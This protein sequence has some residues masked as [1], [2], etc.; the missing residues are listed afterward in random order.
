M[1]D[2]GTATS[3]TLQVVLKA[4]DQFTPVIQ[5][6]RAELARFKTSAQQVVAAA[7]RP[8]TQATQ[9]ATQ[10]TREY[11]QVLYVVDRYG[12]VTAKTLEGEV[13]PALDKVKDKTKDATDAAK[14]H[15]QQIS[16]LQRFYMMFKNILISMFIYFALRPLLFGMQQLITNYAEQE[17][18]LFR[19]SAVLKSTGFAARATATE[20]VDLAE[21]LQRQ[22]IYSDEAIERVEAI[23]LTFTKLKAPVLK[24]AV[25]AVLDMSAVLGT[26]LQTAAIRVGKALQDP[27]YGVTALRRVGVNL[28]DQ[29]KELIRTLFKQGKVMEAQRVILDELETEFGGMAN[30]LAATLPGA[31]KKFKNAFG[32]ILERIG[33]AINRTTALNERLYLMARRMEILNKQAELSRQGWFATA[34]S[35]ALNM[36]VEGLETIAG[37]FAESEQACRDFGIEVSQSKN[38]VDEVIGGLVTGV[39]SI[40]EWSARAREFYNIFD[41]I[42]PV[43]DTIRAK[44]KEQILILERAQTLGKITKEDKEKVLSIDTEIAAKEA[45]LL[46]WAENT[47]DIGEKY[48]SE[49]GQKKL[50]YAVEE[51]LAAREQL[52]MRAEHLKIQLGLLDIEEDRADIEEQLAENWQHVLSMIKGIQP[53]IKG[54]R[55]EEVNLILAANQLAEAWKGIGMSTLDWYKYLS[56]IKGLNKKFIDDLLRMAQL[57]AQIEGKVEDFS[58]SMSELVQTSGTTF[59]QIAVGFGQAVYDMQETWYEFSYNL[60]RD[61]LNHIKQATG[62]FVDL[63][64]QSFTAGSEAA[65]GFRER[66]EGDYY[67]ALGDISLLMDIINQ[68]PAQFGDEWERQLMDL[69]NAFYSMYENP[70]ERGIQNILYQIDSLYEKIAAKE[71]PLYETVREHLQNMRQRVQDFG[72]QWRTAIREASIDWG[73][74]AK[75]VLLDLLKMVTEALLFRAI[76]STFGGPFGFLFGGGG[77]FPKGAEVFAIPGYFAQEGAYFRRRTTALV[78]VAEREPEF[79]LPESKLRR[80]IR[81]EREGPPIQIVIHT[82]DPSTWIETWD[83]R[84]ITVLNRKLERGI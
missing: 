6:A 3:A 34:E 40:N 24:D 52:K 9:Q 51:I 11:S 26:D 57:Y 23:L 21:A 77:L 73:A 2:G 42:I 50:Q 55:E 68:H 54:M 81:E 53:H 1:A 58:Q 78:T 38:N 33:E 70:T 20:L 14:K 30:M 65:R 83:R 67:A 29:T 61:L 62:E 43:V 7:T 75:Q 8:Y 27:I 60:S 25:K 12:A 37:L 79:V 74:F 19:L 36:V 64:F 16:E 69:Q 84:A 45:E 82:H 49:V 76:I 18:A 56:S 46:K 15:R 5:Q 63:L 41:D 35:A 4:I 32:D 72:A 10:A 47:Y 13:A 39:H 48:L 17:E 59:D 31:A 44:Y 66:I 22:T 28:D 71:G 80:L